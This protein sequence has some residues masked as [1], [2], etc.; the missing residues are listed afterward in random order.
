MYTATNERAFY[1]AGNKLYEFFV[2]GTNIFR[3]ALNTVSGIVNMADNGYQLIL[4]D[5]TK[6]YIFTF[7]DNTFETITDIHFPA[8]S[9]MVIY[10]NDY[11]IVNGVIIDD[12]TGKVSAN[13]FA[14]SALLDGLKWTDATGQPVW[15]QNHNSGDPVTGI[16]NTNAYIWIFGQQSSQ[17]W[18]NDGTTPY[19]PIGGTFSAIGLQAPYSLAKLND[20]I[21]FLGSSK[22]GFGQIYKSTQGYTFQ[23]ISTYPIEKDINSYVNPQDAIAFTYQENGH[24]FYVLT[25]L[26]D[27]KTWVY[28]NT[29]NQWHERCTVNSTT[30]KNQIWAYLTSCFAFNKNFTAGLYSAQI[31]ELSSNIYTD[32]GKNVLRERAAS[33]IFDDNMYN[34]LFYKSFQIDINPGIGLT[35]GQGSDPQIMLQFSKDGGHTWSYERW[36]SLGKIG[37]YLTRTKWYQLGIARNMVFR[38]RVSDSVNAALINAVV[39][40]TVGLT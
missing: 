33:V 21:F 22:D 30:N 15:F 34:F 31:F 35:T 27:N 20:V 7:N 40:A 37:K 14:L 18:Y 23:K 24:Y 26:T 5:G 39:D 13:I 8:E 28:D 29:E 11:F 19:S 16:I 36:K 12:T 3:G 6:G 17:A 4:V 2:D 9:T 32:N 10:Q 1:V 38:V 25:F